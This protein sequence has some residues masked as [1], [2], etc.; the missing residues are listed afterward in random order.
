MV[1]SPAPVLLNADPNKNPLA[2]A[3]PS[4]AVLWYEYLHFITAS[5]PKILQTVS[6]VNS[7]KDSKIPFYFSRAFVLS[8]S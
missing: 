5:T 6:W 8:I 1:N 7:V 4:L 3:P 2:I